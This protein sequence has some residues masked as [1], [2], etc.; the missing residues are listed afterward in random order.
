MKHLR[1]FS[2]STKRIF[3]LQTPGLGDSLAVFQ[4][5]CR[6]L[7]F[8]R[9]AV[10]VGAGDATETAPPAGSNATLASLAS[11]H[12]L[13]LCWDLPTTDMAGPHRPHRIRISSG[14]EVQ[15][16]QLC[17]R[18]LLSTSRGS[19]TVPSG[20]IINPSFHASTTRNIVLGSA[21]RRRAH[22]NGT[23]AENLP[24]TPP[25]Y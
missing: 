11:D 10:R 19:T 9:H 18:S 4:A 12:V 15:L 16:L 23:S 2:T 25:M 8:S 5:P 17:G 7:R 14:R 6:T 3:A 20:D 24:V 22:S 1:T 21:Y 13:G